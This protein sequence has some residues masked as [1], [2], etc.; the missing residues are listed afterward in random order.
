MPLKTPSYKKIMLKLSGE[1]FAGESI[2]SLEAINRVC[3]EIKQVRD[4]GVELNVV[5]GGG[6]I[7]R[8]NMG[9]AQGMD[10]A[11]ADYMGM[12]ATVMN[13]LAL[14]NRMLE[15]GIEGRVMT[16]INMNKIAETFTRR[17]AFEHIQNGRVV[18]HAGGIGVPFF[19]TDTAAA[20]RACEMNCEVILKGTKVDGVYS[21]DPVTNPNA[22]F[23][24]ELSYHDVLAQELNV[25]DAASI[26]LAKENRIPIVVFNI[27]NP[28]LLSDVVCSQGNYTIVRETK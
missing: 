5:I 4:M 21:A 25:M 27:R 6:N 26:S 7:F 16:S 10:R 9:Q 20:S 22:V 23:Y 1:I 15:Y 2:F 3:S 18:I 12:L 8:G 14:Q 24:K 13:A 19:S 17:R 11:T 28:G